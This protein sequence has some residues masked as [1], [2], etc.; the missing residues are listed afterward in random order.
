MG[1]LTFSR[2]PGFNLALFF[3]LAPSLISMLAAPDSSNARWQGQKED[4]VEADGEE[5][6]V[7]VLWM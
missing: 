5:L 7:Y 1:H 6:C 3:S 4:Q 2:Y